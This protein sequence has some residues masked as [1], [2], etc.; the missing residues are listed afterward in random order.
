[1]SIPVTCRECAAKN[2]VADESAGKTVRCAEC[3]AP[4]LVAV[5]DDGGD[6]GVTAAPQAATRRTRD[7]GDADDEQRSI[8]RPSK[9]GGVNP[10]LLIVGGVLALSCVI[11]TGAGGLAGVWFMARQPARMVV[12]KP[13]PPREVKPVAVVLKEVPKDAMKGMDKMAEIKPLPA[14]EFAKDFNGGVPAGVGKIVLNQ[15]GRL[16]PNDANRDGKPHK[17]FQIAF[18]QGKT[19]VIDLRSGEMDSYLWLYDPQ[20]IRIAQD[21]DGGG[22][23]DARIRITAA[24]TGNYLIAATMFG[25]L[26]PEGAVFTL[27]VR[28]D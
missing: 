23:P 12:A 1:M 7:W 28:E 24:Q 16:M 6:A 10:V 5:A 2:R 3:G 14:K 20:G 27:T 19:Y 4:M 18:Q 21:D 15:Q 17:P 22:F 8:A 25:G 26:R 9:K 13:A 11:C